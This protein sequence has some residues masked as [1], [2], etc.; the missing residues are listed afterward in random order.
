MSVSAF[1]LSVVDLYFLVIFTATGC[2]Q[3]IMSIVNVVGGGCGLEN[4]LEHALLTMIGGGLG[5]T[6]T[7]ILVSMMQNAQRVDILF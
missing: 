6:S 5:V 2:P 4:A 3:F 1:C 7:A